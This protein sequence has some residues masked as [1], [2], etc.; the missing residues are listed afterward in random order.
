MGRIQYT[1]VHFA[2]LSYNYTLRGETKGIP[3]RLAGVRLRSEAHIGSRLKEA[4][5]K[6]NC[7]DFG[8]AYRLT[9]KCVFLP[10]PHLHQQPD[11]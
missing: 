10:F 4:R 5:S 3:A 7:L 2:V 11:A 9:L 1:D 8:S 6:S